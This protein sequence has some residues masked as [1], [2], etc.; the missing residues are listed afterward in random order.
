MASP[1]RPG[2]PDRVLAATAPAHG[3]LRDADLYLVACVKLKRD[4]PMHAREL[5]SS[6]WF[7]RARACV[8]RTGRPW[9][10]LSAKHGLVWPDQ[11]IAPY[12]QTL[13]GMPVLQRRRWADRVFTSLIPHLRGVRTIGMLA[14]ATYRGLL[15]PK[16]REQH[17]DVYVP[18]AGLTQGMQ[19]RW[20]NQSLGRSP[21]APGSP[22]ITRSANDR[23]EHLMRFYDCLARLERR[24][25]GARQLSDCSGRLPWPER[26]VYFFLEPGET[27]SDTGRGS[28]VVRVG[29]HGLTPRSKSTLWGRLAQHR[30][31]IAGGG[32]HRTS[33]FRLIVGTALIARDKVRCPSWDTPAPTLS[34]RSEEKPVEAAVSAEIGRMSILWL[35]VDDKPGPGSVRGRIERNAIALLSNTR[36][37]PVDP[38]SSGWLGRHCDRQKVRMSGLWNSDH[39]DEPYE[40]AFLDELAQ[41]VD[42]AVLTPRRPRHQ[43]T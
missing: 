31:T 38:P 13:A 1:E 17:I 43:A 36:A 8:E 18:M 16:L 5:Y 2:P 34:T 40:P 21:N 10:I 37:Q 28:R 35:P 3:L 25:G 42:R 22:R 29:T 11:T 19:L 41:L 4:A 30:G 24:L 33:V 26:G 12:E 14:G 15:A 6:P 39:V 32:N 20:L 23:A 27:R 7:R 9:A